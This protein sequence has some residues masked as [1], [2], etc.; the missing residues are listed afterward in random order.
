M[1][2]VRRY[3]KTGNSR[4]DVESAANLT[5]KSSDHSWYLLIW[6]SFLWQQ[7]NLISNGDNSE[8]AKANAAR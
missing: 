2:F 8:F 1:Y 4:D 3:D 5:V 7:R 6:L